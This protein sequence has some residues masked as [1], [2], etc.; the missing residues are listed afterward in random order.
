MGEWN[1]VAI[2]RF[3][4]SHESEFLTRDKLLVVG[5]I[6]KVLTHTL[7]RT[8]YIR[9]IKIERWASDISG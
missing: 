9:D 2:N 1:D 6:L 3:G 8:T 5:G 4:C 7:V